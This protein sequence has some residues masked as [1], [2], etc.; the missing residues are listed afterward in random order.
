MFQCQS[1][2][3]GQIGWQQLFFCQN[4][5]VTILRREIP[6][7]SRHTVSLRPGSNNCSLI[8]STLS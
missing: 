7:L 8:S 2:Q 6:V 5:H 4:P 1:F 3:H